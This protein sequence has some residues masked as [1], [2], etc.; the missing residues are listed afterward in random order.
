M[1]KRRWPSWTWSVSPSIT[2]SRDRQKSQETNKIIVQICHSIYFKTIVGFPGGASNKE[3]TCQCRRQRFNPWVGK[4]PW[5]R[6]WQPTAGFLPGKS[7]GQRSLVSYT[8]WGRKESDT[9]RHTQTLTNLSR[10]CSSFAVVSD[11]VIIRDYENFDM[12]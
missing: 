5:R 4:M 9:A 10:L 6:K 12:F 3:S 1:T 7:P 2:L 11:L 8:P